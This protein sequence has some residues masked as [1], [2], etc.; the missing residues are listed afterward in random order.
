M[1]M[2]N[3]QVPMP[4]CDD[5]LLWDTWMSMFH[6]P[7]LAVADEIGLFA[8]LDKAPCT[9]DE[10][11]T[12][13][14][15]GARVAEALLGVLTSLG[16]LLQFNGKF[17]LAEVSRTF[18]LPHS[19]YYWGGILRLMRSNPITFGSLMEAVRKD[20]ATI[21]RDKDVWEAHEVD[22]EQ[23]R[24]FTAHMH[25]QTVAPAIG[26]ARRGPFQGVKRLL[27]IG[28]GSGVFCFALVREYPAMHCTV[29][30]LPT[31]CTIAREYIA[32]EGLQDRIDTVSGDFFR[33]PLPVGYD[34]LLLSNIVHDWGREK[35]L[36]LARRSFEALPSG[37]RLYLH[38][39]PLNDAKSGPLHAASFS[40][41]LF[42]VTEGKQYS[43]GELEGMLG[44]CGFRDITVTPTYGYYALISA[45]KP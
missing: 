40:V 2:Q 39:I 27:D 15:I 29:L 37:G 43:I 30:E 12:Q 42:W 11:T 6:F 28:G 5:R 16:Y 26:A 1:A 23:A 25:S 19:R 20:K 13:L 7:T 35:C 31:V 10:V 41:C 4:L 9:R 45:R 38:E 44:E 32:R 21:Y 34:A 3:S 18:L 22:P 33:E 36:H 8:L 14:A 17:Y 24:V